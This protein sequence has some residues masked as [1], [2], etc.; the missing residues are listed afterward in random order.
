VSIEHFRA[1]IWSAN[2]LVPLRDKLVFAGPQIVN[3][4]YEGDI[5]EAGD[6][7]HVSQIG[8][9]ETFTYHKGDTFDYTDVDDAGTTLVVDQSDAFAKKLDNVD[10]A[11]SQNGGQVMAAIMQNAAY[12]LSKDADGYVASLYTG[13]A[14]GN[15]LDPVTDLTNGGAN[16]PDQVGEACYDLLV[17]LGVLLDEANA[18]DEGRYCVIPPWFHGCIKKAHAFINA[19]KYGSNT[20]LL[21]G[22]V[23]QAAG[24]ALLK[25]NRTA[26]PSAGTNFIQAGTPMAISFASQIVKTTAISPLP[27][28][29][30]DAVQGLHVYGAKIFYPDG[31]AGVTVTRPS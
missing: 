15:I 12:T 14:A 7:V 27:G 24:F 26:V 20:V 25:S 2:L 9:V 30:A 23:G 5:Q 18:P 6:T 11:Q 17:D 19:E 13:I 4:N 31:L 28:T 29:F 3:H 21:N 16:T 10:A 1:E 8:D 22:E